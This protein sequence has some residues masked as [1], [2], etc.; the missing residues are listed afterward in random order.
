M[1][2]LLL[3][4]LPLLLS[5]CG[6]PMGCAGEMLGLLVRRMSP[7]PG[8]PRECRGLRGGIGMGL[9]LCRMGMGLLLCRIIAAGLLGL[10]GL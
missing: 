4:P 6:E 3:P 10:L 2:I 9:L 5:P 7:G 1:P 8:D